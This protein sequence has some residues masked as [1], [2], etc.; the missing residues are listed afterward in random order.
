MRILITGATGFVGAP[1]AQALERAGHELVIVSRN[2]TTAASRAGVDA[3]VVQWDPLAAEPPTDAV[4]GIDAVFNLMGENIGDGRWTAART[5]AIYDSRVAGTRHLVSGVA[6]ANPD[7]IALWVNFSAIGYYPVNRP[8]RFDESGPAG[9]GFTTRICR[10]WEAAAAEGNPATRHVVLRVGTVL[11]AGGGALAKL[12]LPFRLGVGG[13]VGAGKQ[14]MSW[15]HRDDLVALCLHCVD[16]G[17]CEG[18]LNAVAPEPVSNRAFSRALGQALGR[19][20]VLPAPP[21]MLRLA[22]GE[23]AQLVLDGQSIVSAR[24]A[25]VGFSHRLGD[26]DAALEAATSA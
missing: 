26:L 24:L 14:M 21:F 11:D 2:G 19:P 1:L 18:V 22:L 15:I 17:A 6:A 12:L 5:R 8:E 20:S 7:G 23:M 3:E 4:R 16:N 9:D 10:D 13:P 25:E